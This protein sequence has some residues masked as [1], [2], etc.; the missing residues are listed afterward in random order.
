MPP[1]LSAKKEQFLWYLC[2]TCKVNITSKDRDQH[3]RHCPIRA[4]E[5]P[6]EAFDCSFVHNKM[7]YSNTFCPNPPIKD[8]LVDDLA[9]RQLNGFVFV[10][11][12]VMNLCGFVLGDWVLCSSPQFPQLKPIVRSIWPISNVHMTTVFVTRD[13]ELNFLPATK[14]F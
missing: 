14:H 3:E 1:K 12:S 7:L 5:R 10:S 4:Y 2:E 6:Q 11:E 8:S 13:G 9:E